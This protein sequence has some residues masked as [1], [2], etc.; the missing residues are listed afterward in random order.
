MTVT[1]LRA[2]NS[3]LHL[4]GDPADPSRTQLDGPLPYLA[5]GSTMVDDAVTCDASATPSVTPTS[6]S[7]AVPTST[8]IG[9]GPASATISMRGPAMPQPLDTA[10][11][12]SAD[13][14]SLSLNGTSSVLAGY[15]FEMAYDPSIIAIRGVTPGLCVPTSV[16]AHINDTPRLNTGC[17][18]QQITS[19]GTLEH[20][21]VSCLRDGTSALHIVPHNDPGASIIGTHVFDFN[22]I[23][24]PQQTLQDASVTCDHTADE[25]GDGCINPREKLMGL[26]FGDPWDFYS[27]PVPALLAA[28]N[29]GADLRD[30]VV[31]SG[32]AQ[33][34]FSYFRAGAAV[35]KPVYDE[36]LDDNGVA[37]GVQYDRSVAGPADSGAPD[38]V[39]SVRDAQ[40][41]FAQFGRGYNC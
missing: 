38:G 2:G 8:V 5:F 7:T 9:T 37:D 39:V 1:C 30:T 3:D 19:T 22:A 32:D 25:D 15:D 36:D 27:V 10:F 18:A 11:E 35:G 17:Y 14:S 16:W 31:A 20:I 13:L 12:I 6:T 4:S 34:V 33:A 21:T 26:D 29:P 41:A 28:N 23:E 40:L 24:F